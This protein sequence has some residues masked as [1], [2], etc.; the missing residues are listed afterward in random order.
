MLSGHLLDIIFCSKRIYS[1]F[2]ERYSWSCEAHSACSQSLA[3]FNAGGPI[4]KVYSLIRLP[5]FSP[6]WFAKPG[7]LSYGPICRIHTCS[8]FEPFRD[9]KPS[10]LKPLVIY[11]IET[12]NPGDPH[13]EKVAHRSWG[14]PGSVLQ[15]W[16]VVL[17]RNLFVV[18]WAKSAQFLP[19]LHNIVDWFTPALGV[20]LLGER[21]SGLR[22]HKEY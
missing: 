20:F 7:L 6:H 15:L 5:P 3:L 1:C 10:H 8:T 21:F 4:L 12:A 18:V 16:A 9:R 22:H 11:R 14:F 13:L 2:H 17:L 19:T